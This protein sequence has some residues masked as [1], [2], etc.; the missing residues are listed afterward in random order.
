MP[1]SVELKVRVGTQGKEQLDA[2]VDSMRGVANE[3]RSVQAP[4]VQVDAGMR[5]VSDSAARQEAVFRQL[6][7][8]VARYD[9][10]TLVAKKETAS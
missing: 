3:A 8:S 7:R 2:V 9:V 6:Q 5:R 10:L 1:E 4:L